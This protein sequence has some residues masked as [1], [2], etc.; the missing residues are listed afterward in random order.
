LSAAYGDIG[1]TRNGGEQE[2]ERNILGHLD[3]NLRKKTKG[4]FKT[5]VKKTTKLTNLLIRTA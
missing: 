1:F 2:R 5:S 4:N 3:K